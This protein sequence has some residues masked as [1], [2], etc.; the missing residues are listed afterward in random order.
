ML[1]FG[2]KTREVVSRPAVSLDVTSSEGAGELGCMVSHREGGAFTCDQTPKVVAVLPFSSWKSNLLVDM[3][4]SS[5]VK[6]VMF[7]ER[8]DFVGFRYTVPLIT[9]LTL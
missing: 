2:R 8:L 9:A 1:E 4:G 3:D 5:F 7:Q 6:F